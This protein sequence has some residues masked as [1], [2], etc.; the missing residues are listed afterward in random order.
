[1]VRLLLAD[2]RLGSALRSRHGVKLAGVPERRHFRAVS[3]PSSNP[4]PRTATAALVLLTAVNMLN[5]IDRYVVPAVFESLK[6]SPMAPSDT[7]LGLLMSGFLVVYT[8]TA[9]LFGR[10]GDT[11]NRPRVLAAGVAL[12]SAATALGGVARSYIGLLVA[13]MAVGVG[14]AAYGTVGPSL[15]ADL[16]P[17]QRRGRAFSIFFTAIPVG[18]ALGYMLGGF[19]DHHWGWRRVFFV[20]GAPGL[21]AAFLLLALREPARGAHDAVA[22]SPRPEAW[23]FRSTYAA[24]LRNRVYVLTI[25]GYAAYTFALGGIAAWMP[26]F[27]ERVR[28]L[29]GPAATVRFGGIVVATG[30]LGTYAG[31]WLGD[32][33]LARTR[34]A[35]LWLSGIATLGAAPLFYL[36]LASPAP[37]VY[38]SA[39]VGAQLLMFASTGPIN[40][41]IVNIVPVHIRASAVALSI[42]TIHAL[43][44]VPSPFLVGV[45]ADA[46]SL[47]LGVLILPV[48]ALV[49][50]LIWS[51]AATIPAAPRR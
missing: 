46:R 29:S 9:P 26:P 4:I 14:E 1:M 34:A 51:Y 13:R 15:L 50:G 21:L 31:G 25:L 33:L 37:A 11:R 22:D 41:V 47:A 23:S 39:V 45:I 40:S 44:D 48:A 16:Y 27:L 17:V 49:G 8:L 42:F 20:A 7:Q 43:G 10:L 32:R 19:V 6:R 36:S 5:Y 12:W 3:G 30:L 28:G 38:W 35:Y 24:L 18:A 2:E